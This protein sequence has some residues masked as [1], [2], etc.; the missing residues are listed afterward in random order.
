MDYLQLAEKFVKEMHAKYMK[1]VDK[2][3]THHNRASI[4]PRSS[5]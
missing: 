4:S 1:R 3:A 2:P 5:S